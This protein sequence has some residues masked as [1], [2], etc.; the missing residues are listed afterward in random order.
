MNLKLRNFQFS[1][2]NSIMKIE[3]AS[4]DTDAYPKKRFERLW[5]LHS[6]DFIV[7][8]LKDKI[9]G[10]IIAYPKRYFIDFDSLAVDKKYRN[11]GIGKKLLNF[12]LNKFRRKGFKKA[13]L[14]VRTTNKIATSFYQTLGFKITKIIKNYYKDGGDAYRMEKDLMI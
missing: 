1:D 3:N 2:L 6:K 14:E 7:A 12:I 5:K 4:F 8:E 10:Y 13:S 9:V 11:S